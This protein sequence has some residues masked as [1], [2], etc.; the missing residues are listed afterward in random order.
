M[1]SGRACPLYVI[2]IMI[3]LYILMRLGVIIYGNWNAS[4]VNANS[5]GHILFTLPRRSMIQPYLI[6]L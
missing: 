2:L 4:Y 1:F 5:Y 6:Q 3:D